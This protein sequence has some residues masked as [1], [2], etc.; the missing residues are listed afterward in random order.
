MST[1]CR[2]R[3]YES[4]VRSTQGAAAVGVAADLVPRRPYLQRLIRQHFP[5]ERETRILDLGCGAGQVLL[6]AKELGYQ[7]LS[8]VDIS[9]EQVL[10]AHAAGLHEVRCGDLMETLRATPD[11]SYD[12]V[13]SFDV[14]EHFT[15]DEL[16]PFLDEVHRVLR[17]GGRWIVHAPNGG[18]PFGGM[19]RYGDF[20]HE[21]AFTPSSLRQLLTTAG[22]QSVACFEDEP[23]PHGVKSAARWAIWKGVRTMLRVWVAA[24]TGSLDR[25]VFSQN[26]LAVA[27]K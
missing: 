17:A 15:K 4:Y 5:V 27:V 9:P 11:G 25:G 13:L 8:G 6:V 18:A 3:L 19:V 14:I 2:A 21:L 16:L 7:Q 26:L 1:A 12:V 10:R 20:T 22:F 24:E 23:V